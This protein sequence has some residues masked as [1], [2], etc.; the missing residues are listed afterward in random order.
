MNSERLKQLLELESENSDD[1]FIFYAI[2]LEYQKFDVKKSSEYFEK[3]VASYPDY[4]PVYYTYGNLLYEEENYDLSIKI[5]QKGIELAEKQQEK[6]AL[7]ELKQLKL[8]IEFE[9]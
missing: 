5:V 4:L 1:P 8:N 7:E 6:K 9:L 2:A 3:I